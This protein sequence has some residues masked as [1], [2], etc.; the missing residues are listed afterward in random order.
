MRL[1]VKGMS[2]YAVISWTLPTWSMRAR[3]VAGTLLGS[4]MNCTSLRTSNK[5]WSRLTC[6]W[7][8]L[9]SYRCVLQILT[10]QTC[11]DNIK[12][13]QKTVPLHSYLVLIN[14]L[15]VTR[16]KQWFIQPNK[17]MLFFPCP[18]RSTHL[19]QRTIVDVN[20][21]VLCKFGG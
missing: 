16:V 3:T 19:Y 17:T 15:K 1:E 4:E 8:N 5:E 21:Q 18:L 10:D 6:S 9:L 14:R 13:Q 11:H 7:L 2:V 20:V 12:Q